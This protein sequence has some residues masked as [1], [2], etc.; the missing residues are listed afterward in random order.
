MDLTCVSK[1]PFDTVAMLR[2][3]SLVSA[4][5]MLIAKSLQLSEVQ[6]ALLLT[7]TT[8]GRNT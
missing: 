2:H 4:D 5:D 6:Q 1:L 3:Q 8:Q 7:P